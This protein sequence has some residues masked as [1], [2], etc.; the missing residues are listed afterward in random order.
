MKKKAKTI[1]IKSSEAT[2]RQTK[3]TLATVISDSDEAFTTLE[4]QTV[5]TT[6]VAQDMSSQ[7]SHENLIAS[8]FSEKKHDE[9]EK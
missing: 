7:P 3:N 4:H 8:M 6:Q 2:I 5:K 9:S 1:D